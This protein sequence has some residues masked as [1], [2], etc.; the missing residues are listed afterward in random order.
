MARR[1]GGGSTGGQLDREERLEK[2]LASRGFG[3]APGKEADLPGQALPA[4]ASSAPRPASASRSRPAVARPPRPAAAAASGRPR[5]SGAGPNIHTIGSYGGSSGSRLHQTTEAYRQQRGTTARTVE[6]VGRA[7][8]TAEKAA[9][10][11]RARA[12]VRGEAAR[13]TTGRASSVPRPPAFS[14]RGQRLGD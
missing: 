1:L 14:G 10:V 9:E 3:G 7:S 12:K 2:L 6:E 4:R 8:M 5:T 11:D 13:T